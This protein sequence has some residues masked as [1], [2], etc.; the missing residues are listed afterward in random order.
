MLTAMV[1]TVSAL[2]K[3]GARRDRNL[4]RRVVPD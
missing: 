1:V 3:A 2:F 4:F